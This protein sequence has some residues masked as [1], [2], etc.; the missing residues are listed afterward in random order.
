[1]LGYTTAFR[2]CLLQCPTVTKD[3][4]LHRYI[5]GL[6][7]APRK[8]VQMRSPATLH[9]AQLIAERYDS[10][11]VRGDDGQSSSG[12]S[13]LSKPSGTKSKTWNQPRQG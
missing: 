3:E 5:R 8:W 11:F 13:L 10:T 7:N 9:E 2:R 12:N 4:A 1:M 6:R